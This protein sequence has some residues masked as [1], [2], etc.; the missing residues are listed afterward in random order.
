MTRLSKREYVL[1]SFLA[2]ILIWFLGWNQAVRPQMERLKEA[3]EH[4]SQVE[5]Q[6]EQ[7]E[8][9]FNMQP[10]QAGAA[11]GENGTEFLYTGLDDVEIDRLLLQ[12]AAESGV[13]I[14]RMEIGDPAPVEQKLPGSEGIVYT[15]LNE[16]PLK[17]IQVS[18]ELDSETFDQIA[19]MA[20]QI[21]DA[22]KSVVTDKLEATAVYGMEHSENPEFQ[23]VQC[24]MDVC[25]YY[26]ESPGL[27]EDGA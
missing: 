10:E 17:Y 13:G 25:F 14:R 27:G 6:R 26:I 11:A 5:V 23:G 15:D 19:S 2:V 4:L 12:M 1:I 3:R 16:V 22:E 8:L 21:Y 9:Y 20:E 18:M 7:M 24:T